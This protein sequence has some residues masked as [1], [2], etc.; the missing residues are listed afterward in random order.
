M[1]FAIVYIAFFLYLNYTIYTSL[2]IGF[3][4]NQKHGIIAGSCL[5]LLIILHSSFEFEGMLSRKVFSLLFI[6][7]LSLIIMKYMNQLNR[8]L[9]DLRMRNNNPELYESG[10]YNSFSSISTFA[11]Q[12]LMPIGITFFQMM[13]IFSSEIQ[14]NLNNS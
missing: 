4:E 6:F 2:K 7:S 8:Y 11:V 5:I 9:M 12:V 10:T 3:L 1:I 14:D 13:V